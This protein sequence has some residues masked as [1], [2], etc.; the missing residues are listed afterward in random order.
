MYRAVTFFFLENNVNYQDEA[1]VNNALSEMAIHFEK[2][3]GKDTT[4]L[5]GKNVENKL[6]ERQVVQHVSPVST[7]S[8]VRKILV[9]QQRKMGAQKGI[10]MDGRDIGTVVFPNAELKIFL[11]AKIDIRA[12]RRF[13]ELRAKGQSTDLDAVR[14]NLQQRDHIDSTRADSP[15]R[16]AADAVLIDNSN[17][18]RPEQLAMVLALV[19]VRTGGRDFG[20]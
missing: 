19:G 3:N 18:S 14:L 7:L 11:T 20:T 15:L 16:Q 1:A 8:A 4:F 5:N 17:L 13:D 10:V 12:Q 9:E 2:Q 6:F